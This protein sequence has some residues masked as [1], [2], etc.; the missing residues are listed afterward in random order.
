MRLVVVARRR[1]WWSRA[2]PV[3]RFDGSAYIYIYMPVDASPPLVKRAAAG[4]SCFDHASAYARGTDATEASN[5]VSRNGL[6]SLFS[7]E[8]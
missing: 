6:W 3:V 1:L 8:M 5:D 2:V 7:T 4:V